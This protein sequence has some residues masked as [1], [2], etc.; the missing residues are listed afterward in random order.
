MR[1]LKTTSS[2]TSWIHWTLYCS[3]LQKYWW[4]SSCGGCRSGTKVSAVSMTDTRCLVLVRSTILSLCPWRSTVR[5]PMSSNGYASNTQRHI[6]PNL[7]FLTSNVTGRHQGPKRNLRAGYRA[8]SHRRAMC[9][10]SLCLPIGWGYLWRT[11]YFSSS[12]VVSRAFSGLCPEN[13]FSGLC[14]VGLF[15]VQA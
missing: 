11:P 14:Y 5:S 1:A 2:W 13:A 8:P 9:R 7:P 3:L 4:F 10:Q 15:D 12:S 6:R